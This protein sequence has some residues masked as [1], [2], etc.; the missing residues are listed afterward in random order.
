MNFILSFDTRPRICIVQ[1]TSE[2]P[3]CQIS[4][5]YCSMLCN[6]NLV[7]LAEMLPREWR[8]CIHSVRASQNLMTGVITLKRLEMQTLLM[9]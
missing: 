8:K 4:L 5:S 6:L 2:Q 1:H 3:S 7:T 9:H